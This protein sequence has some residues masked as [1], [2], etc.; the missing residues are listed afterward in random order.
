MSAQPPTPVSAPGITIR[1][2]QATDAAQVLAIY[3][4]GLDSRNASFETTAPT[5]QVFDAAK[6]PLHRH[7][8]ADTS[9]GQVLGWIAAGTVSD[10]CV[11]AG[12]VENSLY[13]HPYHH[14]RGIG[15]ALLRTFIQSTE[16]EGIWTIQSGIF[17]ENIASLRLHEKAGFRVVGT[18]HHIGR[19]HDQWRDVVLI[20]RRSTV[21]GL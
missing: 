20:E 18:R 12:V 2:M 15:T 11:Y 1:P 13:V 5:W 7:V 3:Q 16:T 14:S 9:T 19:H 4:A 21:T 17:P 6:L 8:A 10:R